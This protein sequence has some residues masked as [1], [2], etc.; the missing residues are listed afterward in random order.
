METTTTDHKKLSS[1]ASRLHNGQS[2]ELPD[3]E[4]PLVAVK[5]CIEVDGQIVAV[6]LGRI[7]LNVT[8]LLDH[9]W[10]TPIARLDAIVQLQKTMRQKASA[11]GLDW[12]YAEADEKFGKRLESLGWRRAKNSLYILRID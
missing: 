3:L 12:A 10:A 6:G 7:E 11:L 4:S 5:E 8:L 2:F 1:A 9:G